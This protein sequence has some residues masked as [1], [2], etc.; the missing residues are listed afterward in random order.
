MDAFFVIRY[1]LFEMKKDGFDLTIHRADV[2]YFAMLRP[3]Q[4]L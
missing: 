2:K 4:L 1:S 3:L